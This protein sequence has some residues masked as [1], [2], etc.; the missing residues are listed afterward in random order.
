ML[1][2]PAT[3]ECA[4]GDASS[5]PYRACVPQRPRRGG[6]ICSGESEADG[7]A[8]GG[9]AQRFATPFA[10]KKGLLRQGG[11]R[12]WRM[13][14]AAPVYAKARPTAS[15]GGC[16]GGESLAVPRGRL[17]KGGERSW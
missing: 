12:P 11:N 1:T 17:R 14:G 10:T 6:P 16:S 15:V 3:P 2:F 9:V 5:N 8:P 13:S 7:A 4:A